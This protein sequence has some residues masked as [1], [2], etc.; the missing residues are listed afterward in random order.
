MLGQ[1]KNGP[2]NKIW[3]KKMV[4]KMGKATGF[5]KGTCGVYRTAKQQHL[6]KCHY[7]FPCIILVQQVPYASLHLGTEAFL[8]SKCHNK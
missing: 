2:E 6:M 8:Q 7:M 5:D 3:I 1:K 4:L